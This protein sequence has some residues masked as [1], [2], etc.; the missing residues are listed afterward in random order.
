MKIRSLIFASFV[1]ASNSACGNSNKKAAP[2]ARKVTDAPPMEPA[3]AMVDPNACNISSRDFGDKGPMMGTTTIRIGGTPPVV[4]SISNYSLLEPTDI[5]DEVSLELFT[6]IPPFGTE[7]APTPPV[8]GTYVLAGPD[9]QYSSCGICLLAYSNNTAESL[10]DGEFMATGGTVV[11]TEVGTTVGSKLTF[12]LKNATFE[13]VTIDPETFESTPKNNN[14]TTKLSGTFTGT[15]DAAA[16]LIG[17]SAK[18]GR[19]KVKLRRVK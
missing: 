11:I 13:A 2:D 19:M 1:V 7:A 16:N 4:E 17:T 8:A 18:Q 10:G 6:G 9:L 3:D 15:M 14:C 12:E 5:R